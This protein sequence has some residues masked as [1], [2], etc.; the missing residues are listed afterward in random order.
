MNSLTK[1]AE[2]E[3][4]RN[5]KENLNYTDVGFEQGISKAVALTSHEKSY[6]LSDGQVIIVGSVLASL[7]AFR[8]VWITKNEYN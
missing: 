8:V 6:E 1:T 4:V 7:S 5:I 2:R 3:V